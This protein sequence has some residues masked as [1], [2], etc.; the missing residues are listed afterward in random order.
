MNGKWVQVHGTR[1]G[2]DDHNGNRLIV[3]PRDQV[4]HYIEDDQEV[5]IIGRWSSN[6][7]GNW[8]RFVTIGMRRWTLKE[9]PS[10]CSLQ[11]IQESTLRM[12]NVHRHRWALLAL[13]RSAAQGEG[14]D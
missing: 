4:W 11:V 3:H 5:A 6:P 2:G 10:I 8:E 13:E 1:V 7:Q 9:K 12:L 14:H